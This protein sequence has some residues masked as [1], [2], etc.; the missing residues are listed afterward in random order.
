MTSLRSWKQKIKTIA[1]QHVSNPA[2]RVVLGTINYNRGLIALN[3]NANLISAIFEGSSFGLI[4]IALQVI[5]SPDISSHLLNNGLLQAIGVASLLEQMSQGQLFVSLIVLAIALQYLRNA[6]E[7]LGAVSSDYLSARIQAQMTERIFRHVMSFS[8]TC[9]SHY[10][11]GDLTNYIN[12]AAPT[13]RNEIYYWNIFIVNL[14]TAIAQLVLLLTISPF[15]SLVTAAISV[16]LFALQRVLI[17][18]IRQTAQSATQAQV[19]VAKHITESIQGLRVIHTFATQKRA[20]QSLHEL[21]EKLV[22][23]LEAQGRSFRLIRPLGR[24]LTLTSIGLILLIGFSILQN[25]SVMLLSSL[26]TFLAVLNRLTTYLNTIVNTFG[27]IAQNSGDFNRLAKILDNQDKEFIRAGNETFEAL[28]T[29]IQFKNISLQYD[30]TEQFALTDISFELPKG[31]VIALVGGSGAG[32]S[33]ITDLLIGLYQPTTGEILV[34]GNNLQKF[35]LESWRSHLGVVS[36]DTFIFNES[37]LENIRYGNLNASEKEVRDAAI[38][39]QANQFINE[40]PDGYSTVVGERGYRLSGGQRQRLALAR[41]ILR[42]SDIL[43]LDEAT[44]ALDSHSEKLVQEAISHLR[45]NC[46]IILVAHRLSTI[47]SA[48]EIL[49]I[50]KGHIVEQGK[51]KELLAFKKHYYQYW[52]KQSQ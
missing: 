14:M 15:L 32:K 46:T 38:A 34:D 20:I 30:S 12:L 33:S 19:G 35:T 24:A 4:F 10:K 9:A 37:I 41:A 42:K 43:V 5:E 36:Q 39:A 16:G 22:P 23:Q 21:E 28:Q 25:Q 48:D 29:S 2:Y 40:L 51:H 11:V 44:S 47:S 17:P 6:L 31:K 52:Q 18:K 50:E 3:F 7:Y 27:N 13:V 45:E 8:F 1:K 49:V 26:V